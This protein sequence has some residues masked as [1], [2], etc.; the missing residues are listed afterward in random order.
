MFFYTFIEATYE[1]F[2]ILSQLL[3]IYYETPVNRKL[4]ENFIIVTV[5]QTL[6]F[7]CNLT[8]VRTI[9]FIFH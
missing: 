5:L 6:F 4:Y 7:A 8:K 2:D 9:Y 3:I 1:P